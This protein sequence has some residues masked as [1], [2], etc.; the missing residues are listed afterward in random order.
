MGEN[1]AIGLKGE[2]PWR[3][4]SDL[5]HFK[6]T[7][8]GKPIIIGRR[9]FA[10]LPKPLSGR[11]HIILTRNADFA[12][13]KGHHVAKDFDEACAIGAGIVDAAKGDECMVVGGGEIYALALPKADRLYLSLVQGAPKADTFFPDFAPDDWIEKS[14]QHY[15]KD[16]AHSHAWSLHRYERR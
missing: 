5:R 9:T 13:P 4:P 14:V 7:T 2:L 12:C 8:L 16:D 15:P 11:P 10:T 3:L 6:N 1:R